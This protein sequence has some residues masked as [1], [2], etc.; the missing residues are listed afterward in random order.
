MENTAFL[1]GLL[2][3]WGKVRQAY[4]SGTVYDHIPGQGE[5]SWLVFLGDSF[6]KPIKLDFNKFS[7]AAF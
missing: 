6:S 4:Y 5:G 7:K 3:T 1:A 2:S